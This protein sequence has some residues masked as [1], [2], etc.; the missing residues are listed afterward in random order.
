MPKALLRQGPQLRSY[1]A[2]V[3]PV[4]QGPLCVL[5][6]ANVPLGGGQ[7]RSCGLKG[8]ARDWRQPRYRTSA[9]ATVATCDFTLAKRPLPPMP[10]LLLLL[11]LLHPPFR[12]LR[13]FA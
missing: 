1:L 10:L 13:A 11:L 8:D 9:S 5:P 2:L 6:K 12:S 3:M 7:P 4:G